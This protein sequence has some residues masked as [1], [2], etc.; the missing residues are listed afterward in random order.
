MF[1]NQKKNE[2]LLVHFINR[3]DFGRTTRFIFRTYF[4]SR[5]TELSFVSVHLSMVPVQIKYTNY[6]VRGYS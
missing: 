4:H 2:Y 5:T 3:Y 1:W 6:T